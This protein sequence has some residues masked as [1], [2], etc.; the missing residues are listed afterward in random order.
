MVY[1]TYNSAIDGR[2]LRERYYADRRATFPPDHGKS[3]LRITSVRYAD[4][5]VYRA[6][7]GNQL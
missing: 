3:F 4:T 7:T 2:D 5:T 1:A 6:E